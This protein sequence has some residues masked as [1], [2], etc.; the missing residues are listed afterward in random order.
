[1]VGLC[2]DWMVLIHFFQMGVVLLE[3]SYHSFQ[4]VCGVFL[5]RMVSGVHLGDFSPIH[6]VKFLTVL[7]PPPPVSGSEH[8]ME[9]AVGLLEVGF[10]SVPLFAASCCF[11]ILLLLLNIT[12]FVKRVCI[13]GC[14]LFILS[15]KALIISNLYIR[16]TKDCYGPRF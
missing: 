14:L 15:Y 5:Y 7:P 13:V 3:T 10:E 8:L 4:W 11:Q 1:M 16:T 12:V 2:G 9:I 6:A